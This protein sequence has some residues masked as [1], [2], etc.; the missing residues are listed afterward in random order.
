MKYRILTV[1]AAGVLLAGTIQA[2]TAYEAAKLSQKDLNGTARFVGMG[3]AMGALGGDISTI[4]TNPAGIGL[5]RK[6]DIMITAGFDQNTLDMGG[7]NQSVTR[8]RLNNV[9]LVV[10]FKVNETGILRSFNLAFNYQRRNSFY[11]NMSLD[12]LLPAD[13][14]SQTYQMAQ[15]ADGANKDLLAFSANKDDDYNPLWNEEIGWLSILGYNA[16]LIEEVGNNKYDQTDSY[17][18]YQFNSYESGGIDQS[19][20]NL[21]FNLNDRFY[22]G[23][24]LG[25]YNVDYTKNTDYTELKTVMKTDIGYTLY[26]DNWIH[27]EGVNF[28]LGAIVRPFEESSFR[29]GFAVHT[30]IYYKLT[31]T[32]GSEI[33]AQFLNEGGEPVNKDF[34]TYANL[35]GNGSM[36]RDFRLRTPWLFNLSAGY[37]IGNNIALGAEYEYEDY[38]SSNLQDYTGHGL[39]FENGQMKNILK[40]V[41]TL[42]LGAEVKLMP[43]VAFRVGYNYSSAAFDKNAR[44]ELKYNSLSTNTDFTNQESQNIITAGVGVRLTSNLYLDMAYKYSGQNGQFYPFDDFELPPV[45]Q[46]NNTHSFLATLGFRF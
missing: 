2:Q 38:A 7:F 36:D 32:T 33:F 11:K 22:I 28:K 20:F 14:V 45:K 19:E 31:L 16:G 40:G 44:K 27:G 23:A 9:G 1:M 4:S 35:E 15:Q 29:L 41:H 46:T 30:P 5:F 13:W 12:R 17:D 21:S 26:S 24:T 34:S 42:R 10:P 39:S 37:T 6:A 8:A 25:F 43:E 3:G 18:R